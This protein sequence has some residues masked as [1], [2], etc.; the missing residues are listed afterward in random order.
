MPHRYI[1]L[2]IAFMIAT[3][4]SAQDTLM[5]TNGE[6][7][8][9]QVEEIQRDQVRYRTESN[10]NTVVVVADKADLQW[11]HLAG[12]QRFNYS[13]TAWDDAR[14]AAFLKRRHVIG[15]DLFA[16]ALDHVTIAFEHTI[17]PRIS[18]VVKAGKIG[19]W[20]PD[21]YGHGL[22]NNG[23]LLKAGPRLMLTRNLRNDAGLH[24][25][26]PLSGWYLRPEVMYSYWSRARYGYTIGPW[27]DP[28][29]HRTFQSSAAVNLVFGGQVF[30]DQ[31]LCMDFHAGLGY[32]VSWRNGVVMEPD[33]YGQG[34]EPYSFSHTFFAGGSPFCVSGGV[35]LGYAF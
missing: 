34:N 2:V 27:P 26:H 13:R 12:G 30:L 11:V 28:V 21:P 19:L 14:T 22:L 3:F 16:P 32:G 9:G 17:K 35:V 33:R 29:P 1:L 5:Y 15:L 31:R 23:Y 7:I 4:A 10:G 25:R 8:I 24:A 20:R 6:R 18:I